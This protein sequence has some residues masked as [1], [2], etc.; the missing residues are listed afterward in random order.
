MQKYIG[1]I[2]VKTTRI[3][4]CWLFFMV[5][6]TAVCCISFSKFAVYFQKAFFRFIYFC[7]NLRCGPETP[8]RAFYSIPSTQTSL[9]SHLCHDPESPWSRFNADLDKTLSVTEMQCTI[10]AEWDFKFLYVSGTF[11]KNGMVLIHVTFEI[12]FFSKYLLTC[13]KY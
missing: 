6:N 4:K 1:K 9:H 8:H 7:T 5:G 11:K 13:N 2:R 3:C 12:L 10:F